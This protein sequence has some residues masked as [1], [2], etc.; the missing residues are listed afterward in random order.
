MVYYHHLLFVHF[1]FIVTAAVCTVAIGYF[2]SIEQP[3]LTDP[4]WPTTPN[5]ANQ[6]INQPTNMR[7]NILKTREIF[8][9]WAANI[10]TYK[11]SFTKIQ[12][13]WHRAGIVFIVYI[14]WH[15]FDTEQLCFDTSFSWHVLQFKLISQ[16]VVVC[17]CSLLHHHN[18]KVQFYKWTIIIH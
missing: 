4:N 12:Y 11:F 7:V 8:S 10:C 15:V 5:R 16:S 3:D 9:R 18:V 17:L 13:P 6:L 14:C 1:T 2:Q